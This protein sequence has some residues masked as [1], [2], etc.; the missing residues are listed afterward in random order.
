MLNF[1]RT[2]IALVFASISSSALL[3]SAHAA[4][5]SG[6]AADFGIQ[7]ADNASMR[8]I[9]I[10]ANTKW[11][12]VTNGETVRFNVNGQS[13]SWHFDTYHDET[14]FHLAKIAPAGVMVGDVRVFVAANPLY[15]G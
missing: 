13:F 9:A 15:R 3:A 4:P 1:K 7:V 2:T 11:V 10:N 8:A 6:S 14:S 5:P 12:N